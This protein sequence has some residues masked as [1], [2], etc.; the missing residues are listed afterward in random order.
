MGESLED[1]RRRGMNAALYLVLRALLKIYSMVYFR[2]ATVDWYEGWMPFAVKA[3]EKTVS[4]AGIDVLLAGRRVGPGG[5]VIGL[6][7]TPEMIEAARKNARDIGATNIEFR[8]GDAEE[9][10]VE[11]GTVDWIISNCVINLAPD[12]AKVFREAYRVLRPGGKMLVSDIVT[13]DLPEEVRRSADAWASCVAG[14]L[15]EDDYL[16]AIRGAGF[17]AVD[18]VAR[19]DYDAEAIKAIVSESEAVPDEIARL[20]PSL[21]GKISSIKVSAVKA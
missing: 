21:A 7:M 14:A 1:A 10:P 12:K 4:G 3:A 11:S 8:L 13:H 17:S 18:V 19:L 6:D 20:A 9:M 15:E 2:T 16:G 5:H